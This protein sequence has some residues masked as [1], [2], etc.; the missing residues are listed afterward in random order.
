MADD[1]IFDTP[2]VEDVDAIEGGEDDLFNE[3]IDGAAEEPEEPVATGDDFVEDLGDGDMFD[4]DGGDDGFGDDAFA[5]VEEPAPVVQTESAQLIFARKFRGTVEERD[6]AE[7][8]KRQERV[9][10]AEGELGQ[11]RSMRAEHREKTV[12]ANVAAEKELVETQQEEKESSNSWALVVKSIDTQATDKDDR[13]D[14]ARMRSVLI[15]LKNSP[16]KPPQSAA[17]AE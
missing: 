8:A 9:D 1:D 10:R 6:S 14:A 16:L 2:V 13:T 3:P 7:S 4:A 17:T 12:A 15:Q 11:W 5:A